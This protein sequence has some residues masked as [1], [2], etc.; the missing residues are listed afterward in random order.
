MQTCQNSN[1]L[2]EWCETIRIQSN[3]R[4]DNVKLHWFN[5]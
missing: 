5:F 4:T 3:I 2:E 1:N